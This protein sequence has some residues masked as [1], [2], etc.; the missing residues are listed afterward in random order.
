MSMIETPA[1]AAP[2]GANGRFGAG[3]PGRPPGTASS[4]QAR[5]FSQALLDHFEAHQDEAPEKLYRFYFPDYVRLLSRLLP[6]A[7]AGETL[8]AQGAAWEEAGEPAAEAP[9]ATDRTVEIAAS[10]AS[11]PGGPPDLATDRTVE[12]T[13]AAETDDDGAPAPAVTDTT[14][15]STASEAPRPGGPPDLATDTT[16]E[17]AATPAATPPPTAWKSSAHGPGQYW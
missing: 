1:A 16:V 10:K 2:R 14:V 12:N 9:A 13:A 3:N 7:P 11:R 5:R 17:I 4:R 15:E 8:E 6:K